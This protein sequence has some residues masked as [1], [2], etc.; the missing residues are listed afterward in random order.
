MKKAVKQE[1][2][3]KASKEAPASTAAATAGPKQEA[4]AAEVPAAEKEHH[5][6]NGGAEVEPQLP[7]VPPTQT[8]RHTEKVDLQT[9]QVPQNPEAS[10]Y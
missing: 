5:Q 4:V 3:K 10:K 8:N 1:E 9:E 7:V 2:P 6:V